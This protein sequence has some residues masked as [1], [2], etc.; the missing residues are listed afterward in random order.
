MWMKYWGRGGGGDV[1]EVEAERL[2]RGENRSD[3]RSGDGSDNRSRDRSEYG[4]GDRSDYKSR[5][6]IGEDQ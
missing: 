3:N 4:N 1:V 6:G 5:D 2:L